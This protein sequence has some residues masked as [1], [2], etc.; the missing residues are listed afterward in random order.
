MK[1]LMI[2]LTALL[3]VS[4]SHH[5]NTADHH[6]H[7]FNKKCAYEVGQNHFNVE[8]K[9]EYKIE[10]GEDTYYFS[11]LENKEKFQK[12]LDANILRSKDNWKKNGPPSSRR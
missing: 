1:L 12:D 3:F 4:C 11:S 9:E 7:Q 6:H 5:H 8:G 2:V 10:H